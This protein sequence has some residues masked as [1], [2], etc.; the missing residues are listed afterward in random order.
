MMKNVINMNNFCITMSN[1]LHA[2]TL[3]EYMKNEESLSKEERLKVLDI[4]DLICKNAKNM[5]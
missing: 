1:Y 5:K 4:E 3:E 2:K